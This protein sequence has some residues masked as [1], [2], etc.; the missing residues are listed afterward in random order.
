MSEKTQDLSRRDQLAALAMQAL[1]ARGGSDTTYQIA[2]NAVRQ[3]DLLIK[4]LD[5]QA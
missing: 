2:E 5:N 1:I 3:A 4:A